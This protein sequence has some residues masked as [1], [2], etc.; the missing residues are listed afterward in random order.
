VDPRL[1]SA[2]ASPAIR[3][4]AC[5]LVRLAHV[6]LGDLRKLDDSLYSRF[7][8]SREQ[9]QQPAEVAEGLRTVWDET[10]G[11]L[12]HLLAYTAK[13]TASQKAKAEAPPPT[14]ELDFGFEPAEEKSFELE[15]GDIGELVDGL[16]PQQDE[17]AR[18][19]RALEIISGI[20]YGL[21][22]Q[23]RDAMERLEVALAAGEVTSVLGLLDETTSSTNEAI[24]ALVS[25]VF[26]A[27]VSDADTANV[28]PEYLT[29]LKRALKVRHGIAQLSATLHPH[30]DVLQGTDTA[31]HT[32]ALTAIREELH[33][34]VSSDIWR[35]MR[36]ADR[37]ELAQFDQ[38]LQE[39]PLSAARLTAEGL[40]KYLES[41][42]AINQREVLVQHD[43]RV[44]E[45]LREVI[46][47]ARALN[48]L[49]PSTTH[50][51]LIKACQTS[52]E[53]RGRRPTLDPLLDQNAQLGASTPA[54]N[55]ALIKRL[56]DVIAAAG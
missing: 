42:G 35:A 2:I 28:V 3:D 27:F 50:E 30:N 29:T 47:N 14:D 34:F 15:L 33:D 45:E 4:A 22:S 6:A 54:Q 31:R 48:D 5:E 13:L 51:L 52:L 41:L 38:Q 23:Y 36:A 1:S 49:S 40:V 39:K 18:W 46:T 32:D 17:S 25:A 44:L 12:D 55:E 8:A 11:S 9:Q 19:A 56:E 21:D 37:W 26:T 16:D 7:V 53:L 10:F 20:E 24:H 43:E